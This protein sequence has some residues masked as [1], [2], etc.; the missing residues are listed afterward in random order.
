[1]RK[2]S[3]NPLFWLFWLFLFFMLVQ[4]LSRSRDISVKQL[5]GNELTEA[6]QAGKVQGINFYP[7]EN[8]RVTGKMQTE[9]NGK[10]VVVDFEV[11]VVGAAHLESIRKLAEEKRIQYNTAKPNVPWFGTL[12]NLLL[13]ASFLLSILFFWFIFKAQTSQINTIRGGNKKF[14]TTFKDNKEKKTFQDVAGCDE[15]KEELQEIVEFLKNPAVFSG[16]GGHIP[17]GVLMIGA[18]GTGKTLLAK[19]L[20]G[21]ANVPFLSATGSEFIEMFVGVGAARVRA[22]FAEA[23]AC[24]PCIVFIDEV[25]AVGK[26][27]GVAIGGG[28]DERE[29]TLDQILTELDGFSG[30][31]KVIVIAATN[32]P[33]VLDEA[34]VRAGRFD[35]HVQVPKPDVRGRELILKVHA[36]GVKLASDVDLTIVA[37]DT[38]GMVGA[39]LAN[40]VNE[41]ALIAARRKKAAADKA[42]FSEAVDKVSMGPMRKSTKLTDKEKKITAY[43]ESG[44]ALVAMFLRDK[45]A[46]PVHKVTIIPRGPALGFTKQLPEDDRHL[47]TRQQLESMVAVCVGGRAAEELVIGDVT[48]G[49]SNDFLKATSI[50]RKMVCELGMSEAGLVVY[51][52]KSDF[53][54]N[55]TGMDA[56]QKTK[57]LIERIVKETLDKIYE[58]VKV[59]LQEHRAK[60]DAMANALLERETL[61]AKDVLEIINSD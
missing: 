41:A 40:V 27:R 58:N 9:F 14:R 55:S 23:K 5:S 37:K 47:Y 53:W 17:K 42:D 20:A 56:S 13:I 45:G 35:R 1:M 57:E 28:H 4:N 59:I 16:V 36:K 52:E 2:T 26:K 32:R 24:A 8:P 61:D 19:A 22:L 6:M 51:R 29:Q 30:D 38:A 60:L 21:E 3:G 25:D 33:D 44:H 46:D 48:T 15:A 43:H 12:F 31:T 39:D 11:Q 34:L 50:L 54:G 49:A 10:T 18:P 7:T